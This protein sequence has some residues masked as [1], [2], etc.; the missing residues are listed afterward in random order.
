[1]WTKVTKHEGRGGHRAL[2]RTV[3]AVQRPTCGSSSSLVL[4][5]GMIRGKFCDIYSDGNGRLA[6]RMGAKGEYAVRAH[7]GNGS[8]SGGVTI[9]SMFASRIPFGTTDVTLEDD[10]GMLVLDLNAL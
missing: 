1:M 8:R 9:P 4:P 10:G 7:G 3:P 5:S 2:A 6:F